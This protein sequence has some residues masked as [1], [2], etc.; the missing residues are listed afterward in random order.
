MEEAGINS[1][2]LILSETALTLIA[3]GC[4]GLGIIAIESM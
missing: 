2:N 1:R 3:A 4:E